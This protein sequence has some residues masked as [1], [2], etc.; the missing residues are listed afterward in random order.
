MTIPF[1]E[2]QKLDIRIGKILKVEDH[3]DAEK[4][5]VIE[6]DLGTEK[7]KLV[8][9]LKQHYDKKKL[10]GKLCVVFTNIEPA[11]IRGV[12]SNGMVLAAVN[13]DH[14]KVFLIAPEKEIELGAKIR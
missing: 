13:S 10:K 6:V 3:P 4:L 11:K 9:G 1:K 2:W 12:E 5:Y 14:S 7:R 8:A